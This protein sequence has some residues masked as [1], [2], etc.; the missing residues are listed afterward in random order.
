MFAVIVAQLVTQPRR[1][2]VKTALGETELLGGM[3]VPVPDQCLSAIRRGCETPPGSKWR[4]AGMRINIDRP[5]DSLVYVDL[6]SQASEL[7]ARG[8]C[9]SP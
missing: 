6:P 9:S 4:A 1:L 2:S 7:H 5:A 3:G 8:T